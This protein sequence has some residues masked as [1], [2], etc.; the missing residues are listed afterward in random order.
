[1]LLTGLV[2]ALK[3]E[4]SLCTSSH[5]FSSPPTPPLVFL[6]RMSIK[7]EFEHLSDLQ[8]FDCRLLI[9]CCVGLLLAISYGM[10][11]YRGVHTERLRN[12]VSYMVLTDAVCPGLDTTVPVLLQDLQL[13]ISALLVFR[14]GPNP[15]WLSVSR[16]P[17]RG[18]CF[19]GSKI[20]EI[21]MFSNPKKNLNAV[22]VITILIILILIKTSKILILKEDYLY[23]FSDRRTSV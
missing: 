20:N 14:A 17:W 3:E 8:V 7:S 21:H 19:L 12:Y 16:Q 4:L 23:F 15:L 10:P 13:Y 11:T 6:S 2:S 5:Q 22:T 9:C 18:W 1:M